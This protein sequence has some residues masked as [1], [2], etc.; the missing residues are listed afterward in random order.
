MSVNRSIPALF[1][2]VSQ[3]P[4]AIR[5]LEQCEALENGYTTVVDG[6]R[7]RPPTQF[8]KVMA[9]WTPSN[10]KVHQYFRGDG[11]HNIIVI[12]SGTPAATVRCFDGTTGVEKTVDT[13]TYANVRNY[14]GT[15]N[16]QD[17][18]GALT[19]GDTTFLWNRSK[20]TSM[21]AATIAAQTP[22]LFIYIKQGV[23][24][25]QG[26][27]YSVTLDGTTVTFAPTQTP[28]QFTTTNIAAALASLIVGITGF[29]ATSTGS[30]VTV[31]KISGAD[32]T[33]DYKDGY[34]STAMIAFKNRVER[35]SDLPRTFPLEGVTVE[36]RGQGDSGG[37]SSFW[38]TY[39]NDTN[40]G[41]G[42]WEETVAPNVGEPTSFDATTMPVALVR[43][44]DGTFLLKRIA[45]NDRLVGS[46]AGNT[47]V[48]SFIGG[49]IAA[50]FFWRNRLGV[51]SDENCVMSRAEQPLQLLAEER[52]ARGRRRSHRRHRERSARVL[53]RHAVPFQR[54]LMLFSD[55]A[56]FP[57][58]R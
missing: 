26:G 22:R 49:N 6:C 12:G 55:N 37:K 35:Y 13:T 14:L 29:T 33:F 30:L 15:V 56:Q 21:A 24:D 54:V 58:E 46:T 38:V 53:L 5:A 16:A 45:W 40:H 43:Q 7:K 34:G 39:K 1:Q 36:V 47:P 51:L 44:G 25:V 19:V 10:P 23:P 27:T 28:V 2:G 31:Q 32:F 11:E 8:V 50:M 41:T 42:Y 18:I 52:R 20:P 3:Q 4:A 57:D 48:P 17:D 9:A